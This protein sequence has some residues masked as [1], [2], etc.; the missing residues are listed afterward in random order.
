MPEISEQQEKQETGTK[1][2]IEL[3]TLDKSA[4]ATEQPGITS[5]KQITRTDI[6]KAK[7]KPQKVWC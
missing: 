6:K 3:R 5:V 2:I 4:N 1:P 7:E